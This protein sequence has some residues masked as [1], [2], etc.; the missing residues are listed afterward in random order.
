MRDLSSSG[1]ASAAPGQAVR[2]A[3]KGMS[4]ESGGVAVE[5]GA[6]EKTARAASLPGDGAV[7]VP[8]APGVPSGETFAA[9]VW[10]GP[11]TAPWAR[12]E[13]TVEVSLP[14]KP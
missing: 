5:C 7:A 11:E 4:A 6:M 13:A 9:I 1:R 14:S 12:L 10:L 8:V 3:V 2:F